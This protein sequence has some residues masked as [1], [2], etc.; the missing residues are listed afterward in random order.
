MSCI[1]MLVRKVAPTP[2]RMIRPAVEPTKCG[3]T[4]PGIM[5]GCPLRGWWGGKVVKYVFRCVTIVIEPRSNPM[6]N[7][8]PGWKP[9]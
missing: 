5:I 6:L 3:A 4:A 1:K 9:R 2:T 8:R 7:P